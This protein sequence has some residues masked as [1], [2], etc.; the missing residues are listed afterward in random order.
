[1]LSTLYLTYAYGTQSSYIDWIEGMNHDIT[2]YAQLLSRIIDR[3][4]GRI[5]AS[6]GMPVSGVT[7]AL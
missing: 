2:Y 7:E 5:H 3:T 6:K 4:H 1:M